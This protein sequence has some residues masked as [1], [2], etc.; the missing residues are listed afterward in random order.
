MFRGFLIAFGFTV[1]IAAPAVPQTA[2]PAS[3]ETV[4][5]DASRATPAGATFKVPAGWRV[6]TRSAMVILDPPEPDS[7][8]VIVDVKAADAAA[9]VA[10]AWSAYKPDFNR[11]L[12]I[13]LPQAAR[14]GWE[15]RRVFQ[16]ETSPN[17]RA[18]VVALA[19]R[20][21]EAWTIVFVDGTVPNVGERGAP[22]GLLLPGLGAEGVSV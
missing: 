20:A 6:T 17:E 13:A 2:V 16:Y 3:S 18:V 14:E 21:G 4:A 5:Q 8:V 12:K 10:S 19:S 7:H 9:A 11:P 15:E 22:L 1:L